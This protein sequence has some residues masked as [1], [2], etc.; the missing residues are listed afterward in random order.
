MKH[1]AFFLRRLNDHTQYLNRVSDTLTGRSALE[2]T[3][4]SP[5][6]C[7]LGSWLYG[8]GE[9]EILNYGSESV[10]VFHE[11]YKEHKKFHTTS[12]QALQSHIEGDLSKK[13]IAFTQMHI[14]SAKLISLLLKLDSIAARSRLKVV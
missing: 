11:L 9:K 10:A 14:L 2:T 13:T 8:D 7:K 1:K 3:N 5:C 12:K 4:T 6:S